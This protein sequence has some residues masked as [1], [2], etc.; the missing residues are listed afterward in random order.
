MEELDLDR[1]L[2]IESSSFAHTWSRQ[3]FESELRINR[4]AVYR[5]ARLEEKVVGYG[6]IWLIVD[7]AH[8]T[9]LAVDQAYRGR[10]IATALLQNLVESARRIGATKMSLEVRPS[11]RIARHLYEGFGFKIRGVRKR[12]YPDEDALIMGR[13]L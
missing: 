13:E 1:V 2:S 11:N 7:E 5:V 3:S 12:Y 8:L 10:G 6:G 4:L 9:T